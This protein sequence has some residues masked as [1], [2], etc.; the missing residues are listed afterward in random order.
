MLFFQ[1]YRSFP[2]VSFKRRYHD[3]NE[4]KRKEG[5]EYTRLRI[6]IIRSEK[7]IQKPEVTDSFPQTSGFML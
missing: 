1:F 4:T 3:T 6:Q 5:A 2:A 7:A